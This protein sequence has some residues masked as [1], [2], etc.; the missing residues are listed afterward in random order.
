MTKKEKKEKVASTINYVLSVWH[1]KMGLAIVN[2][3]VLSEVL[4]K[5]TSLHLF[6]G[7]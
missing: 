1:T 7:I 3:A 4:M 2:N 6:M 5:Q